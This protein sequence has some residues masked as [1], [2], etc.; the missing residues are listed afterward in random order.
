MTKMNENSTKSVLLRVLTGA[1]SDLDK[2][3]VITNLVAEK[4]AMT[5]SMSL[6]CE[7]GNFASA[8]TILAHLLSLD[9]ILSTVTAMEA[10]VKD[11]DAEDFAIHPGD[12]I[13]KN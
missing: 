1:G 9:K 2:I 12:C 8:E 4:L 10:T 11:C 7:S 6:L 5:E 13:Q 3:D